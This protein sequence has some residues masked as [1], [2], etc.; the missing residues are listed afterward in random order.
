MAED[1]AETIRF[2]RRQRELLDSANA[3]MEGVS[4]ELRQE[5][6]AAG[7]DPHVL[8][9]YEL[10]VVDMWINAMSIKTTNARASIRASMRSSACR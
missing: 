9:E 4:S 7:V 6:L 3:Q 5:I 10:T 1:N 2:M 8:R